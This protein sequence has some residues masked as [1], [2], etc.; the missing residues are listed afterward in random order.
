MNEKR[1][2]K[3]GDLVIHKRT[4]EMGRIV[5]VH[6]PNSYVITGRPVSCPVV[7]LDSNSTFLD[8]PGQTL[9]DF[10]PDVAESFRIDLRNRFDATMQQIKTDAIEA[11]ISEHDAMQIAGSVIRER[12]RKGG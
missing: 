7:V 2:A 10:L 5:Q 6:L 1:F 4:G 11:G 8:V 3:V 12:L 9:F